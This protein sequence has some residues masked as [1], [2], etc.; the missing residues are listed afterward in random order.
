VIN[1]AASGR[2]FTYQQYHG[3]DFDNA[4]VCASR[5]STRCVTLGIP[6]TWQVTSPPWGLPPATRGLAGRLV[7]AYLWIG[8]PWLVDQNDPFDL[9]RSLQLAATTPF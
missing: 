9:A 2:P 6:P 3:P 7:D 4:A 8:R 1:T 5:S